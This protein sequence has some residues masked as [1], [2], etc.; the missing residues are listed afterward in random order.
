MSTLVA[1][2]ANV[3]ADLKD[4]ANAIWSAEE[5]ARAVR[6]ALHELSWAVPRRAAATLMA[7]EGLREYSL[8]A[9][10]IAGALY[11]SEVWHPFTAADPEYPPRAVSWRLL[12]DDTLFLDVETVLGGDGIRV[13]YARPQAIEGLDGAAATT[14]STE[15]E[16]LVALGAA[17]YSALQ[18]AQESIGMVNVTG[19]APRLWRDWG[20]ARL[21][22]FRTRL[23]QLAR[24]EAQWC[25]SWTG[26][27][28]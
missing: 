25:E 8:S 15:Q 11:V 12:D 20:E 17:G 9:A 5:L 19:Q 23:N 10:G 1:I 14:L 6:W 2:T 4:A 18:R 27:W 13:L 28:A 3:A 16:E 7:S 26:G 22:T 21:L 24:R